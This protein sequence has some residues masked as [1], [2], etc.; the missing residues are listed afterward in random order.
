MRS[1]KYAVLLFGLSIFYLTSYAQLHKLR[2]GTEVPLQYSVGYEFTFDKFGTQIQ[3][4]TLTTPYNNAILGIIEALGAK[5][6]I[7]TIIDN[8]FKTGFIYE[9]SPVYYLNNKNYI[10]AYFQWINLLA[11][12]LPLELVQSYFGLDIQ[13]F[14]P[15]P[16][17][18]IDPFLHPFG[19]SQT[20]IFLTS[21]LF[22]TGLTY[23]HIFPLKNERTSIITEFSISKNVGS[24][25]NFESKTAYPQSY[26]DKMDEDI[27]TAYTKYAYIPSVN[28]YFCFNLNK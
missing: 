8:S 2:L 7:V 25:N 23:G 1:T 22:Q 21:H 12:D 5:E 18:L 9:L 15:I 26:Y 13:K 24:I 6:N 19:N 28:I 14:L 20:A 3:L 16:N 4:G 27:S 10:G 17:P 11:G